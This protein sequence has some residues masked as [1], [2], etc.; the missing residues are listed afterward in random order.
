MNGY[1][2]CLKPDESTSA[3]WQFLQAHRDRL[4]PMSLEE[5]SIDLAAIVAPK[6]VVNDRVYTIVRQYFECKGSE[7]N[8]ILI[9]E[10]SLQE[11]E[12][13]DYVKSL[14]GRPRLYTGADS[15]T[16][17]KMEGKE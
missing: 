4:I 3:G 14:K 6:V 7:T 13:G 10:L 17:R 8:R 1:V 11:N 9:L 12:N 16:Q 2:F 15:Y 5:S